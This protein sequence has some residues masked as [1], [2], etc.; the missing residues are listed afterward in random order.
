MTKGKVDHSL[1]AERQKSRRVDQRGI[2]PTVRENVENVKKV[3]IEEEVEEEVDVEE[4][5]NG[6]PL[7]LDQDHHLKS[8]VLVDKKKVGGFKNVADLYFWLLF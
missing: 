7:V 8:R 1:G 5:K 2:D 3:E 4:V 6:D